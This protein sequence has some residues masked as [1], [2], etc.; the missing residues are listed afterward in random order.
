MPSPNKD[1]ERS[2]NTYLM[3]YAGMAFQFLVA[4]GV[5]VYAGYKLDRLLDWRIPIWIW[6]LPL[7]VIIGMIAGVIRDSSKK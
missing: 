1:P 2:R 4:I 6:V 3:Q 7:L 5:T